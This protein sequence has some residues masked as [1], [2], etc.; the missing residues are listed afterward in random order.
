MIPRGVWQNDSRR[1]GVHPDQIG[2]AKTEDWCLSLSLKKLKKKKKK[3]MG[4]ELFGIRKIQVGCN[5]LFT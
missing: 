5:A 1:C 4:K 2:E 3:G